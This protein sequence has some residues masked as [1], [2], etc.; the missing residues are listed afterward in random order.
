MSGLVKHDASLDY[1]K[2]NHKIGDIVTMTVVE[3]YR[4][5]QDTGRG[6]SIISLKL[7]DNLL[8]NQFQNRL[9]KCLGPI[10]EEENEGEV[11]LCRS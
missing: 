11:S 6:K 4:Y 2:K 7:P 5:G 3:D 10:S 8:N 1:I 9:F